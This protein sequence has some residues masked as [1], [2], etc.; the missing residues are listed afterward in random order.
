MQVEI[1]DSA[2]FFRQAAIE[3]SFEDE[4]FL[5]VP[6]SAI[7]VL[8]GGDNVPDQLPDDI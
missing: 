2:L 1:G 5:V 7:L 8:M 4:D 6:H 3:I